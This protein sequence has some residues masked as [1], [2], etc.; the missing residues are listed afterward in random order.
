MVFGW[1]ILALRADLMD[2]GLLTSE[3]ARGLL[4]WPGR[5]NPYFNQLTGLLLPDQEMAP[6]F[7]VDNIEC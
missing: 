5:G 3:P 2:D 7:D 6:F 1:D 4:E